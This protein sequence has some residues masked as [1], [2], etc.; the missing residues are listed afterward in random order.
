[1]QAAR[2]E[3][4]SLVF[5]KTCDLNYV[6][7][8]IKPFYQ[9]DPCHEPFGAMRIH[10]EEIWVNM[11]LYNI[12]DLRFYLLFSFVTFCCLFHYAWNRF[13]SLQG[14]SNKFPWAGAGY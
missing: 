4:L 13:F 12:W 14:L 6:F 3:P 5:E 1:M 9:P 8:S 11:L 7:S 10:I 2:R